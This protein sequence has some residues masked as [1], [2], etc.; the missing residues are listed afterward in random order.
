MN[1]DLAV[2]AIHDARPLKS[3]KSKVKSQKLKIGS[4]YLFLVH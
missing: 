1:I 3:Q 2:E 4:C